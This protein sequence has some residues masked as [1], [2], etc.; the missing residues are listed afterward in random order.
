VT[1]HIITLFPQTF[2]GFTTQ[3][4]IGR[5]IDKKIIKIHFINPRD[6]APGKYQSVDA[7]PYGG[8]KGMVMRCDILVKALESLKPKPY[9]VLLSASGKKYNQQKARTLSKKRSLAIICGHYE[10][11]DVRVEKFVDEV[12]SIGDFVLT[13]GEIAAMAVIDSTTRLLPNVIT[14]GSA[15]DESF[16]HNLLEYPQY[17]RPEVFRG[18]KVPK[19]LLS[20]N[21]KEIAAWRQKESLARTKKFRSDLLKRSE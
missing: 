21:H 10:G 15:Q 17:T 6:F 1:F 5:A 7:R 14:K 3:S 9:T 20:G 18:L 4:I 16:A 12:I 8:G 19:V 13:G 11:V 2:D